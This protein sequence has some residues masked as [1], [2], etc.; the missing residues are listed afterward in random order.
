MLE[1]FRTNLR[2]L[3]LGITIVIAV[4][5]ALSGT[6]T[7]FLE[8]PGSET[9]LIVNGE[10]ISERDFQIAMAAEKNRILGQNPDLDQAL[11]DD[12]QIRPLTVQRLVS[13]KV[14]AQSAKDQDFAVSAKLINEIIMGVEQFQTDGKFDQDKFRFST[15]NQG[16]ASSA[17]FMNMLRGDLLVQQFS[18]G[19]LNSSFV[20]ESELSA[21][22][23]VTEQKRDFYYTKL[24][25]QPL[26]D[27][28]KVTEQ[29]I[30]DHYQLTSDQYVT[31]R[32]VAVQ[33]IELNPQMLMGSQQVTEE[34]IQA[35]FD[36]EAESADID[37]SRRAAH[38]LLEDASDSLIAEIQE[39]IDAGINFADL[40]KQYSN[41]FA[42]ANNGG[43]LGFT[44]GETFPEAFEAALAVLEIGQVSAPISTEAGVHFIKLLEIQEST[45]LLDE[46]RQRITEDL[47]REL[48]E[49]LLV[50]KLEQLKEL[51][52][53]AENLDEVAQELDLSALVT[54]PFPVTG[55]SGIAAL[56][57]VVKAAYSPEVLEDGYASEVLDLG[58]DR[59]IVIK[60]QEDIAA[61]QLTL[62]E[63]SS[64]V[65][66]SL[67]A[68]VAQKQLEAQGE[69]LLQRI[70]SGE[71]V[72][73]VANSLGLDWQV[74]KDSKRGDLSAD[75]QVNAFA[76]ELPSTRQEP[77]V[78][79]FYAANG[80]FV[81]LKLTQVTLGDYGAMGAQEKNMLRSIV[82]PTYSGR[83][84]LSYQATLI[85]Q[86][87]VVQ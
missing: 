82:E 15:R 7:L 57:A 20:T 8:T 70:T 36:L 49:D 74:V 81:V 63:V 38:I 26:K 34:Q 72:E 80:D 17:D 5:F 45:F 77:V 35:R 84:I 31:Q 58:N 27:Q 64:Q 9:A 28:A 39:K 14:L 86:A 3:A 61:R 21:L 19:I 33:Y 47:R 10:K 25:I 62:E 73:D 83:E 60:L 11:L 52:F 4:I 41:D 55:G 30:A 13:R 23:T 6:G 75:S 71:S 1:N 48:A 22:A 50:A 24:P 40:A 65:K 68:S 51:S 32:Q 53:N 2:G 16:Y 42:T 44:T 37:S 18:V 43:D 85:N 69:I 76:F 29:A 66:D 46:Q 87:D 54:E 12:Q 59:Y 67:V 78:D 79:S 56:P